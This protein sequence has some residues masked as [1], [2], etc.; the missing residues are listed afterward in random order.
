MVRLRSFCEVTLNVWF[1]DDETAKMIDPLV[2]FWFYECI[3]GSTADFCPAYITSKKDC[4][5]LQKYKNACPSSVP[6]RRS[7]MVNGNMR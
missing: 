3:K 2:N 7:Y 4:R 1:L 5:R 6:P